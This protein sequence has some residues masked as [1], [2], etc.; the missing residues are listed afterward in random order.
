MNKDSRVRFV[1][2]LFILSGLSVALFF[3]SRERNRI[4]LLKENVLGE[5]IVEN[6][7]HAP[8]VISSPPLTADIDKNY[9]YYLRIFDNDTNVGNITVSILE[10]P[11]WLYVDNYSKLVYGVPL[12][13]GDYKVVLELND[14]YN[15]SQHSFYIVVNG[16]E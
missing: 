14:G 12:V 8:E 16:D 9:L 13:R 6:M 11:D 10:G 2:G 15:T 4:V 3:A 7:T 5:S 1:L